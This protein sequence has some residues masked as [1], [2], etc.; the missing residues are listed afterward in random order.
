[1]SIEYLTVK[2]P[3]GAILAYEVHGSLHLGM[4]IPIVLVCGM[5]S[6]RADYERLTQSLS[7]TRP[8]TFFYITNEV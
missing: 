6:L 4:R 1:M 2:L 8:G 3:D 5:S 7:Q